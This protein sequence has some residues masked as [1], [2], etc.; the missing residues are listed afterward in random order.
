M[1]PAMRALPIVLL[2]LLAPRPAAAQD[3]ELAG[4]YS[5]ARDPRDAV[6]LPAGWIAGAALDVTSTFSFVAEASGQ[7]HTVELFDGEATLRV[8]TVMGGVRAAARLGAL[9]EFG[10]VAVGFVQSSG[11]AFG[12]TSTFR[13][14]GLQPGVGLDYPWHRRWAARAQF[15]V[16]LIRSDGG[17]SNGGVQYRA[18]FALVY[19]AS[20]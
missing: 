7:Y 4:G 1:I 3:V 2:L 6:T 5:L 16:R 13:S 20:R 11:S 8:H 12:A 19:R 9:R 14:L 15:D 17:A 18:A 10:Q